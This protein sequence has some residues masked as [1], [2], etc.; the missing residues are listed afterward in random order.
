MVT[1]HLGERY[2]RLALAINQHRDGYVDSYFGPSEWQSAAKSRG[3]RPLSELEGEA[4]DLLASV[5][6]A[7]E[8]DDQRRTY[9]YT[10]V[11]A[12]QTIIRLL[13]GESLTLDEEVAGVFDFKPTWVDESNF[14]QA[15][16]DL[17]ELLPAGGTLNERMAARG[18]AQEVPEDRLTGLCHYVVNELRGRTKELFPLP[19]GEAVTLEKLKVDEPWGGYHQFNGDFHSQVQINARYPKQVLEL[20]SMLAHETYPGHHTEASIKED[21]LLRELGRYEHGLILSNAPS[22]VIQEGIAMQAI[23]VIMDQE[24]LIDWCQAEIFPRADLSGLDAH[25]EWLIYQARWKLEEAFGNVAFMLHDQ[26]ASREEA[27]AYIACHV[28]EVPENVAAMI[29]FIM[30]PELRSYVFSYTYGYRL[31]ERLFVK[32]GRPKSWFVRLLS[33]PV[34]PRMVEQWIG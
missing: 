15:R 29:D 14:T 13:L 23:R 24:A 33:E 4:G 32:H 11:K 19:E 17:N 25:R 26:G 5:A 6:G 18:K 1:D 31:L 28:P 22:C 21:R 30:T 7:S 27:L 9:L 34:T 3:P 16:Q 8:L 12:M 20:L 2:T 10:E